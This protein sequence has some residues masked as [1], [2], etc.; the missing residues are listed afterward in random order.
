[1]NFWTSVLL[2]ALGTRTFSET[3]A[4]HLG[5]FVHSS[6]GGVCVSFAVFNKVQDLSFYF[7]A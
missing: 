7:Y 5:T 4:R 3:K 2:G 1:M 6:A